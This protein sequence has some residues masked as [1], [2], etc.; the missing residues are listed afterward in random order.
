M[1]LYRLLTLPII[2]LFVSS[3]EDVL[4]RKTNNEWTDDKIWN[5][6]ELVEGTLMQ[7]YSAI[8]ETPNCFDNNFL[9][10]ATDNAMTNA[11]NSG[12]Y[13]LATGNITAADNPIGNWNKCYNQMQNIHKFME[14]GLRDDLIYELKDPNADK[15]IKKRL[16]GEAFFLRAWWGF[17][18]LQRYGGRTDDGE[19]LGYPIVKHFIEADEAGDPDN[20]KRNTYKEC[21][22]QIIEDCDSA[23]N[24]LPLVYT[25]ESTITGSAYIGRASGMAAVVLKSRVALYGASP[26]FQDA[27]I[28]KINGM[29]DFTVNNTD[30][31]TKQWEYAALV[32]D[33]IFRFFGGF[34]DFTALTAQNIADA[35]NTTPND[36]VF[37]RYYNNNTME[38]NHYPPY[39]RGSALN[40]PTQ[41]FVDAFYD[42]KGFPITDVRSNYDKNNP[43]KNR[44]KRLDLNV[45]YQGR[46]FGNN[47]TNI[48]VVAGGKDSEEYHKD[49]SRTGYYLAKFMST[50]KDLLK[51]TAKQT[52]IHYNPILRKAEVF[53]N[54]AEASNEAYG[55]KGKGPDCKYSAY[56]VIKQI[57]KKSGG[58]TNDTYL[59]EIADLGKDEFRKLIQN[60]RRLEL[61]FE[62]HRYFDIRRKLMTDLDK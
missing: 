46:K 3:C 10:A 36:F 29:G 42:N 1:K 18:L 59:D 8:D 54:F 4:E 22:K 20:F 39:Y 60:E 11:Y 40:V 62:N 58:F 51:P 12:I 28:V 33:T 16:K 24:L 55:P 21:V 37:R 35:P 13:K 44:D 31:Y 43:Y 45:Y 61:A 25:G 17:Q 56:D 41:N 57:R 27:S 53:L 26:A 38:S 52:S 15:E 19:A 5:I 7:A 30:E 47:D 2:I 23:I 32:A 50:K 48:N 14:N 49:A 9:D 6:P 34:G